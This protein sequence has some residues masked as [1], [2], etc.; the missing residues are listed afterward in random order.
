MRGADRFPPDADE[1]E[2]KDSYFENDGNLVFWGEKEAVAAAMKLWK[3]LSKP[4]EPRLQRFIKL[5]QGGV[6]GDPFLIHI[7]NDDERVF[8][9]S[10]DG[11]IDIGDISSLPA[12]DAPITASSALFHEV[13]EQ[14]MKKAFGLGYEKAHQEATK[15][16]ALVTGW[17]RIGEKSNPVGDRI[18][19]TYTYTDGIRRVVQ[20]I[21]GNKRN[22]L[23]SSVEPRE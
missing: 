13:M 16:E 5:V 6:K 17:A 14:H 3:Q 7:V 21:T 1:K 22:K 8:I 12:T 20:T 4:P 18:N 19:L 9:G 23:Q 2:N 15:F 10:W 11:L